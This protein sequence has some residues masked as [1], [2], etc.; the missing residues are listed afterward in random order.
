VVPVHTP[1]SLKL[2]LVATFCNT[3]TGGQEYLDVDVGPGL[4]SLLMDG[5]GAGLL[6]TAKGGSLHGVK[7]YSASCMLTLNTAR[8]CSGAARFMLVLAFHP[9]AFLG[10][11][12]MLPLGL[13]LV[14]CIKWCW[15][16]PG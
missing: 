14:Q 4:L 5:S 12:R 15:V 9:R 1:E 16:L 7:S 10:G 2:G 6:R 3:A 13:A 11:R 8:M